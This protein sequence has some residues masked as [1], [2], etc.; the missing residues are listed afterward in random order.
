MIDRPQC[1]LIFLKKCLIFFHIIQGICSE[2]P[3]HSAL[4][5]FQLFSAVC[6]QNA[7]AHI[8][9]KPVNISKICLERNFSHSWMIILYGQTFFHLS[10]V[11]LLMSQNRNKKLIGILRWAFLESKYCYGYLFDN[12]HNY[13][14]TCLAFIQTKLC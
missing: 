14:C 3:A 2:G 11:C 8:M 12:K 7:S 9:A 6:L 4:I 10:A 1:F 5:P 13:L